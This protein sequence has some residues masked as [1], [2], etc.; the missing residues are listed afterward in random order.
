MIGTKTLKKYFS[1]L[2]IDISERKKIPIIS[3]DEDIIWIPGFRASRK[4]LKDKTT[5]EVIFFEYG[6]NI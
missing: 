1:D 3:T 4:F 6:E 5:K 2:K